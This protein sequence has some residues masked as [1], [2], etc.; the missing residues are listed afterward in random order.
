MNEP[1]DLLAEIDRLIAKAEAARNLPAL[2]AYRNAELLL[3][4]AELLKALKTARAFIDGHTTITSALS[5]RVRRLA[6]LYSETRSGAGDWTIR[7][8]M[9]TRFKPALFSLLALVRDMGLA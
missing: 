3:Q 9:A 6:S 7:P 5:E 8:Q 4:H 2:S 1:A